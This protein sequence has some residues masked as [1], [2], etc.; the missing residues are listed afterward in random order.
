MSLDWN[1]SSGA[2]RFGHVIDGLIMRFK[3]QMR[4]IVVVGDIPIQE[5]SDYA[6]EIIDFFAGTAAEFIRGF[7][8]HRSA[9]HTV[10]I[11]L[12]H[13]FRFDHVA[14]PFRSEVAPKGYQA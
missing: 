1:V 2:A 11:G 13:G 5:R 3:R 6:L 4:H 8:V 10:A 9:L 7:Y 14:S 12:G